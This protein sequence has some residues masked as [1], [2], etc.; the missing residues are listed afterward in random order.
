MLEENFR[1]KKKIRQVCL[2]LLFLKIIKAKK[3]YK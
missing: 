2:D 1:I 3:K